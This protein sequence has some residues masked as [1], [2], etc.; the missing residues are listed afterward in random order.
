MEQKKQ[1]HSFPEVNFEEPYTLK[2]N[3]SH[4]RSNIKINQSKRG[5]YILMELQ[6]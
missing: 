1:L 2:I 3:L 6:N 4:L 5:N